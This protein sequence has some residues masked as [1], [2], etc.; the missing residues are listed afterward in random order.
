MSWS[1][2][3]AVACAGALGAISRFLLSELIRGWC[4]AFPLS[5]LVVNVLGCLLFGLCWAVGHGR[6][7]PLIQAA[8]LVGFLG[9]FTTFSTFA[10]DCNQLLEQRQWLRLLVNLAAQ[11]VLGLLAVWAGVT[12]VSTLRAPG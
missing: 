10:F 12:L 5:T 7:T 3:V 6:W 1:V 4:G 2:V 11:N 8:V 9:A